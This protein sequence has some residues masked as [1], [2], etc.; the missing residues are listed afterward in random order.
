MFSLDKHVKFLSDIEP[1]FKFAFL[2]L[3][4]VQVQGI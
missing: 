3:F 1:D 4:Q 2:S